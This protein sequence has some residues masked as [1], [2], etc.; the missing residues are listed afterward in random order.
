MSE[1]EIYFFC[2]CIIDILIEIGPHINIALGTK[3]I[4]DIKSSNA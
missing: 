3:D 4:E 1:C 2:K